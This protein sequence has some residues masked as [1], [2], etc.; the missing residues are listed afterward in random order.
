MPEYNYYCI[1]TLL[2]LFTHL[3]YIYTSNIKLKCRKYC[4]YLKVVILF[5]FF[6]LINT[7]CGS[8]YNIIANALKLLHKSLY[9]NL[10]ILPINNLKKIKARNNVIIPVFGYGT[11]ARIHTWFGIFRMY[12][13]H[14][15]HV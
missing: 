11:V 2:F 13:V 5:C 4:D 1:T 3:K 8:F 12:I 14:N 7:E 6:F 9:Y 15:M 10:C